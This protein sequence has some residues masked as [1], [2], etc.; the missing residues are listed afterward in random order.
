MAQCTAHRRKCK[1]RSV[2]SPIRNITFGVRKQCVGQLLVRG[3]HHLAFHES[4]CHAP[5]RIL[6]QHHR[7]Q[8]PGTSKRRREAKAMRVIGWRAH[9]QAHTHAHTCTCTCTPPYLV[10]KEDVLFHAVERVEE[11]LLQHLARNPDLSAGG[12]LAQ[13]QYPVCSKNKGVFFFPPIKRAAQSKLL[14]IENTPVPP[15][16]SLYVLP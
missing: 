16:S 6:L 3:A 1:R 13:A 2:G 9:T 5:H 10:F 8:L 7:K 12:N 4:H 14:P 15:W 11:A